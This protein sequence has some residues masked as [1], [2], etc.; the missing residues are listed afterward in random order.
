MNDQIIRQHQILRFLPRHPRSVTI[1]RLKDLL[2]DQGIEVNARTLQRDMNTLSEVFIGID[3]I[4]NPDNSQSWFWSEDAPV[5]QLSGLTINQA[6]SFYLVKQYLTPLLPSITLD[7]LKPFFDQAESTLD[8]I[9]ENK[10]AKWSKKIAVVSPTQPLK[11]PRNDEAVNKTVR[12]ALLGEKQLDILYRR[13]DDTILNYQINPIGLVVRNIITYLIATKVDTSEI[14]MFSF[15]RIL[16]ATELPDDADIPPSFDI[17]EYIDEGHLGFNVT[18]ESDINTFNIKLLF[19]K[20]A[21]KHLLET[22]LSTD[23]TIEDVD[24]ETTLVRATVRE[25]EQLLWWILSFGDHVTVL[26]PVELQKK[27]AEIATRMAEN[28]QNSGLIP[29]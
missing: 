15:H 29:K 7:E 12:H 13:G 25:N 6:L 14:R 26:E 11:P 3:S 2:L 20:S 18:G 27:I 8:A 22:P 21:S 19:D 24:D 17:Q 16:E 9:H 5:L 10:I 28:Y 1:N 4:R 23:Q